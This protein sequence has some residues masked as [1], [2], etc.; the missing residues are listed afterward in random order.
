MGLYSADSVAASTV[1]V[2]LT[3]CCVE[4]EQCLFPLPAVCA[5]L[6]Y[7]L[8]ESVFCAAALPW[9]LVLAHTHC[10]RTN[11]NTPR[12]LPKR[13]TPSPSPCPST[14]VPLLSFYSFSLIFIS[15][16]MLPPLSPHTLPLPLFYSTFPFEQFSLSVYH[17][18]IST[19]LVSSLLLSATCLSPS[20]V[21][22]WEVVLVCLWCGGVQAVV[23]RCYRSATADFQNVQWARSIGADTEGDP[24]SVTLETNFIKMNLSR[25]AVLTAA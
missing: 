1:P 19:T 22:Q 7:W 23:L 10:S 18:F 14:L 9:R 13:D 6:C 5:G 21:S 12:H 2:W 15:S 17:L 8:I 25:G 16:F 11:E 4:T 24:W 3:I 20:W